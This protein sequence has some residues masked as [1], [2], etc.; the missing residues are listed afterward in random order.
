[1]MMMTEAGELVTWITCTGCGS[2][3]PVCVLPDHEYRCQCSECGKLITI[4]ITKTERRIDN[5]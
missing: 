1:M 4:R 5:E 3:S 2:T